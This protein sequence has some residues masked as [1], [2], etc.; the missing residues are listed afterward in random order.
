MSTKLH[1]DPSVSEARRSW[2][3]YL[4]RPE[5]RRAKGRLENP[6]D[7]E[8]RCCLGHACAAFSISGIVPIERRVCN[9]KGTLSGRMFPVVFYGK[10]EDWSENKLP[11]FIAKML[12]I[13]TE[14]KFRKEVKIGNIFTTMY[15]KFDSLVPMNDDID[16]SPQ[17]IA[18]VIQEQFEKDN[19][20][21]YANSWEG[22]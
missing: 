12:D 1:F 11:Y 3:N 20:V 16:I 7:V 21:P 22:G 17:Q 2:L 13:T 9:T 19:F 4:R 10:R 5:S 18:D 6:V 8:H 15:G 14:G